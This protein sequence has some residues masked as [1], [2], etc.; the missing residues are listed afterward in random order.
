MGPAGAPT[1][2]GVTALSP[3]DSG[4][5]PSTPASENP[6]SPRTA[7]ATP[8]RRHCSSASA[9]GAGPTPLA[10]SRPRQPGK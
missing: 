8:A 10:G 4:R 5:A 7:L 2:A 3:P 1:P 9:A 6:A